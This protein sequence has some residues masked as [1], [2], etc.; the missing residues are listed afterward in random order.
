MEIEM[1]NKIIGG[2]GS[3]EQVKVE[4]KVKYH[5]YVQG[6]RLMI[7]CGGPKR[8]SPVHGWSTAGETRTNGHM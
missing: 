4:V 5:G 6:L 1:S 3:I 8:R 7:S 2:H